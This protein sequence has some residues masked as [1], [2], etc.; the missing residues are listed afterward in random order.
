MTSVR[1][2]SARL[3]L[4]AAF[5]LFTL[6]VLAGSADAAYRL[7]D[8]RLTPSNLQAG[9]HPDVNYKLKPDAGYA[10]RTG[11][12]DLKTV[13]MD[14]PAGLLGNPEAATTKCSSSSFNSD[15]CP[16]ASQIGT[17]KTIVRFPTGSLM[18]LN[19]TVHVLS[20]VSPGSAA[21][22]GFVLRPT[23]F[24]YRKIFLKTEATG[25]VTVR[26]GTDKDYGLTLTVDN[27]PRSLTTILNTQISTT[28][29]E[30]TVDV[31]SRAGSPTKN[32]D[33]TY[34]P[35]GPYFVLHADSLWR[36]HLPRD[37]HHIPG[38]RSCPNAF[39]HADWL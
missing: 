10:D 8:Y 21:T 24:L 7:L 37:G 16:L 30:V 27:I 5:A 25:V 31:R 9:G 11:G 14:F 6:G 34:T 26:S 3:A 18:T 33:G 15:T 32:A 39:I 35:K 36:R 13:V 38:S 19:G 12:D 28:V 29:D 22:I 2:G 23:N 17:I 4:F 20:Q 1:I